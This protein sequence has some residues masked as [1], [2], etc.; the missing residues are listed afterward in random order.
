MYLGEIV[1]L[2]N[3]DWD[4]LK[5]F[6]YIPLNPEDIDTQKIHL[7]S[8]IKINSTLGSLSIAKDRNSNQ[9]NNQMAIFE[10]KQKYGVEK[11]KKSSIKTT[12]IKNSAV[13]KAKRIKKAK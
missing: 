8:K 12:S 7:K 11:N 5:D 3:S 4:Y 2:R 13:G 9:I 6:Y 1:T 10:P